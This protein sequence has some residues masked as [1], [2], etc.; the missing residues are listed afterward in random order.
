MAPGVESGCSSTPS[1]SPSVDVDA[2]FPR[3]VGSGL[4]S[5]V[6]AAKFLLNFSR[7][8]DSQLD[9]IIS[10]SNCQNLVMPALSG[11]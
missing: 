3:F 10:N 9:K 1:P 8:Y 11:S 5:V 7:S 4:L 2:F 6:T